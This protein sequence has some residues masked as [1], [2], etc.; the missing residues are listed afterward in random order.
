VAEIVRF[1][2]RNQP[3]AYFNIYW[4]TEALYAV[5]AFLAIREIFRG[6]FRSFYKI[7]GFWLLLPSAN[8]LT[9][10]TV[11]LRLH[12][13]LMVEAYPI[14]IIISSKIAVGFLQVGLFVLF[15]FLVSFFHLGWRQHSFGIALG[16]GVAAA[17]SLVAFLLRSDHICC[18]PGRLAGHVRQSAALSS[19]AG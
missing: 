6:V 10:L 1:S 12:R 11:A 3:E 2:F 14:I 16:F 18:C 9:L 5:L 7:R 4:A 8:T 13:L 17:G 15:F 19:A